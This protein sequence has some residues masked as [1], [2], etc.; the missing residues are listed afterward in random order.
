MTK[1][2]HNPPRHIWKA[3]I[4]ATAIFLITQALAGL[5]IGAARFFLASSKVGNTISNTIG[6]EPEEAAM[7]L[8]PEWL[9]FAILISGIVSVGL[10]SWI[11]LIQWD[12]ALATSRINKRTITYS[13]AGA[14]TGI[15]AINCGVEALHV[16]DTMKDTF[17]DMSGS[18]FCLLNIALFG[19]LTE[20]L[21]FREAIQGSMLRRGAKP[22][23]SIITSAIIF[24]AIHFNWTQ[25]LAGASTGLIL[26]I[27]YWKTGS[28][29]L[30]S[31]IHIV[32]NSVSVMQMAWYGDNMPTTAEQMG[33]TGA[34]AAA[35]AICLA[36]S[37]WC[38]AKLWKQHTEDEKP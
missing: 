26:A 29:V 1:K 17:T 35:A 3:P 10:L 12:T 38:M 36:A 19:P 9:A 25:S 27:I 14:L 32:N 18:M 37:V 6:N 28:I 34:A 30:P 23:V 33:S 13:V 24:G 20:E 11:G 7:S 15:F 22:W 31:I 5:I 4:T 16:P 8:P 2:D 21:V